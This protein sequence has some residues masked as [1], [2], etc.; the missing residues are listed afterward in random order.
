M[1]AS[2]AE[3]HVCIRQRVTVG[4]IGFANLHYL[5]FFLSKGNEEDCRTLEAKI[6][7]WYL[8][9]FGNITQ[10]CVQLQG[11]SIFIFN[12]LKCF[13]SLELHF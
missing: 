2:V 4:R 5:I 3:S 10:R 9:K 12:T 13:Y 1:Y 6:H 11:L 7:G 8:T